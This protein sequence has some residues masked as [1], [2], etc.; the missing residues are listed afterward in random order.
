[1]L[2]PG[3]DSWLKSVGGVVVEVMSARRLVESWPDETED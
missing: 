1:M 2:R 3:L